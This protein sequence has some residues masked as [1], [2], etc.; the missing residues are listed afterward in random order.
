MSRANDVE[1]APVQRRDLVLVESFR[2]SYDRCIHT[3]ER[4]IAVD[5]H[6]LGDPKPVLGGDRVRDQAAGREV[7]EEPNLR[8]NA[9]SGPQEVH[10]FGDDELGDQKRTGVSFEQFEALV[11]VVVVSVD[12]GIERAGVDDERYRETSMRRIS[13]MRAETSPDPLRPTPAASSLRLPRLDPRWAS[14]ASRVRSEIVTPRR[15]ASCRSLASRSSGS[16]T[17]VRFMVCQHT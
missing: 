13:S 9:E 17:V 16:L 14:M 11:M 2:G 15:S 6:K 1:V 5:A 3:A 10:H 8:L 4:E 12:V 7:A